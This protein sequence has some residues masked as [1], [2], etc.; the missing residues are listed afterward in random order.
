VAD[1]VLQSFSN[2]PD[3]FGASAEKG[4][5]PER[6][7]GFFY[8]R[9]TLNEGCTDMVRTCLVWVAVWLFFGDFTGGMEPAEFLSRASSATSPK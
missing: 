7:G 6:S 4:N 5:P 8:W 1:K 9:T 2:A 3:R